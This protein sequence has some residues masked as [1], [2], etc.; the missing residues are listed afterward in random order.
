MN[1]WEC[2]IHRDARL[3]SDFIDIADKENSGLPDYKHGSNEWF[4]EMW[5]P[6]FNLTN[7]GN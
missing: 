5:G 7:N 1:N 3:L 4:I 6:L 2:D